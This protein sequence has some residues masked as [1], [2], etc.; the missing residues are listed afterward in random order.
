MNIVVVGVN[1][2]LGSE[3]MKVGRDKAH[4]M[5]GL[6]HQE[7]E[8]TSAD[9]VDRLSQH[10]YDVL[11]NTA[12]FHDVQVCEEN[13]ERAWEV[14][15]AVLLADMVRKQNSVYVYISTDYVFDGAD[16][17]Y[18]E[19]DACAPHSIYGASKRAGELLT[20]ISEHGI[21]CRVSYLFGKVGCRGK[22]GG[23]FVEFIVDSI[24]QGKELELDA[25]SQ[26]SPTYAV[27]A[28]EQIMNAINAGPGIYH[29]ANFGYC[30]HFQFAEATAS[31]LK[32]GHN[33]RPRVGVTDPLR[34]KRSSLINTHICQAP[35]WKDGL[36]R[37]LK[38]KNYV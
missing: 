23:N 32:R 7:I 4:A 28:A 14:N 2:Q 37:Y 33:F 5:V 22:G 3:L 6:T 18:C 16:G 34:P 15:S 25:D 8:I 13:V 24:N 21:V 12:A 9:D 1:G 27:D 17:A 29:C 35:H 10:N 26:F 31:L 19:S 36:Y 30:N 38:E 11:I 20:L